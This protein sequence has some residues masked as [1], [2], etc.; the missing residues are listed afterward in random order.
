MTGSVNKVI[1]IGHIGDSPEIRQLPNGQFVAR[2]RVATNE[3]WT[4]R[5][6]SAKHERTEW[7][8]VSIFSPNAVSFTEAYLGKGS[9]VYIEGQLQTRKW[10]DQSGQDRYTTEVVVN[11]INGRLIGIDSGTSRDQSTTDGV[12]TTNTYEWKSVDVPF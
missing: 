8:S 7:H 11:P 9:K 4:D 5:S 1:I 10:R 12:G 6:S 2:L 3:T